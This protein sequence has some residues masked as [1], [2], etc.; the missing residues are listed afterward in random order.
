M[1]FLLNWDI[2][3]VFIGK[4]SGC[5]SLKRCRFRIPWGAF[6]HPIP[7]ALLNSQPYNQGSAMFRITENRWADLE[8]SFGNFHRDRG[9]LRGSSVLDPEPKG[10][11]TIGDISFSP[12]TFQIENPRLRAMIGS[13]WLTQPERD[14]IRTRTRV[15]LI[16]NR[17]DMRLRIRTVFSLSLKP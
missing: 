8:S 15:F 14:L 7:A 3:G 5:R 12:H 2:T 9:G 11:L 4:W 10:R 6:S 17:K 16:C 1:I 13:Q